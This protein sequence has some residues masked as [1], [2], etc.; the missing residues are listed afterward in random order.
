[1]SLETVEFTGRK[2]SLV[3][4]LSKV[5]PLSKNG[6]TFI[7]VSWG[8]NSLRI[9]RFSTSEKWFGFGHLKNISADSVADKLNK[10]AI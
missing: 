6:A 9:E 8:E 2:P 5:K 7:E 10:G 3:Q 4:I 1:M